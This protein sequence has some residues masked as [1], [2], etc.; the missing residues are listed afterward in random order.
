MAAGG[1]LPAGDVVA[2]GAVVAPDVL[3]A[4]GAPVAVC[5]VVGEGR[6]LLV[7]DG[8]GIAAVASALAIE[9]NLIAAKSEDE[10]PGRSD[11]FKE[12]AATSEDAPA[13]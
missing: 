12:S 11:V 9:A 10:E 2:P 1:V 6:G 4:P 7:G 3:V 13:K 8:T 5:T